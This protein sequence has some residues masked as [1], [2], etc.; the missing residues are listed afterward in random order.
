M[1]ET[2]C[3]GSIQTNGRHVDFEGGPATRFVVHIEKKKGGAWR[4]RT[5]TFKE[6]V[7]SLAAAFWAEK[8][9]EPEFKYIRVYP[10]PA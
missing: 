1:T 6:P 9:I 2:I 5:V 7:L 3:S 8:H 10:E 4:T